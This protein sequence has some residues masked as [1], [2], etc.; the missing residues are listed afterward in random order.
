MSEICEKGYIPL[1]QLHLDM[2]IRIECASCGSKVSLET[3]KEQG[4]ENW[5]IT[6]M[7]AKCFCPDCSHSLGFDK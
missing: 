6:K 5:T 3:M 2:I 1:T 4:I 7:Y